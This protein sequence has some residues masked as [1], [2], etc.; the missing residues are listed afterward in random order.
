MMPKKSQGEIKAL[1]E[2]MKSKGKGHREVIYDEPEPN[3]SGAVSRMKK[4]VTV[5]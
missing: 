1:V 3:P 5:L 4:E 2:K